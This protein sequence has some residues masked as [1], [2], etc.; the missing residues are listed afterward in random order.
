MSVQDETWDRPR[1]NICCTD[2][3]YGEHD[4]HKDGKC[5]EICEK[6]NCPVHP[7]LPCEEVVLLNGYRPL[8]QY[9]KYFISP[10]GDIFF[11][12]KKQRKYKKRKSF[13]GNTGYLRIVLN[14][15]GVKYTKSVHRLV[16]ET[17]VPK[18][19]GK[20]HVNHKD[21]NKLNNDYTNIEWTTQ[22]E[23]QIHALNNH[24]YKTAVGSSYHRSKLSSEDVLKIRSLWKTNQYRQTD[25]AKRFNTTKPTI[26]NIVNRYTWKHI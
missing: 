1:C 21:G 26:N 11:Y 15:N 23:N 18:V 8:K 22:S 20:P 14:K 12:S 16:A 19:V 25:L 5:L 10:G 13:V 17:F 9:P 3:K 24:L 2:I 7:C 4:K 6:C